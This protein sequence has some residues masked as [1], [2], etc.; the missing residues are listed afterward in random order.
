MKLE[1]IRLILEIMQFKR[2][3]GWA[4]FFVFRSLN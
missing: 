2:I 1:K 4:I 3:T